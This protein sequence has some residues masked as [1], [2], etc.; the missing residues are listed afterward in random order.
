[1]TKRAFRWYR[2]GRIEKKVKRLQRSLSKKAKGSKNRERARLKLARAH[3]RVSN[4]RNDFLHK[5]THDL[6][7]QYDTI[8]LETLTASNMVKNHHLAQALEDIAIHRFNTLLEYKAKENGVN[9]LRIGRFEPSSKMCTCG[10][11]NH[12]LTLSMR[13]WTCP[14]CGATHDRD[15]LAANNIKRFAFHNIHTAGT[16]EIKAC[17]DMSK[18]ACA[19]HEAHESLAH[20]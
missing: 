12:N 20:G 10:Y 7:S 8:C 14:A 19:A 15:L 1:M 6:V 4:Q 2:Y 9:I 16:A 13:R 11:I 18:D 3:E 17:G 5:V